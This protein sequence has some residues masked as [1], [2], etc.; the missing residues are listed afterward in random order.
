MSVFELISEQVSPYTRVN[1]HESQARRDAVR[2][3]SILV[4]GLETASGRNERYGTL[5]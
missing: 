1:E 2:R 5:T 3:E 4:V